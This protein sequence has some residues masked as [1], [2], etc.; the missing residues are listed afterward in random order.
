MR[1]RCACK[2]ATPASPLRKIVT[3]KSRRRLDSGCAPAPVNEVTSESEADEYARPEDVQARPGPCPELCV[4]VLPRCRRACH[5]SNYMAEIWQAS[6]ARH[7]GLHAVCGISAAAQ[8]AMTST[9]AAHGLASRSAASCPLVRSVTLWAARAH[10]HAPRRSLARSRRQ[11]RASANSPYLLSKQAV[12]FKHGHGSIHVVFCVLMDD[13]AAAAA[14]VTVDNCTTSSYTVVSVACRDRK[15]LVYDLFRT[16][17]D[18]HIR[19]AYAKARPGRAAAQGV[20]ACCEVGFC[21]CGHRTLLYFTLPRSWRPGF[22]RGCSVEPGPAALCWQDAPLCRKS[23]TRTTWQTSH[24]PVCQLEGTS[25]WNAGT[26]T[27]CAPRQM[28]PCRPCLHWVLHPS[29]NLSCST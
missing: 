17:K 27:L 23:S 25:A 24:L 12:P 7:R 20:G 21:M 10:A 19:V 11:H 26:G 18:I 14:Q 6:S 4:W 8:A 29:P 13:S 5:A 15:G 1:Q 22:D 16:L 3:A 9:R 2:D 28:L